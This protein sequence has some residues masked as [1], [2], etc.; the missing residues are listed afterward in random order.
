VYRG[1]VSRQEAIA[2]IRDSRGG[3]FDPDV[4]DAFVQ[5]LAEPPAMHARAGLAT[6][7][8]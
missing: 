7:E 2:V 3:H 8:R 1:R 4:A 6:D 5:M